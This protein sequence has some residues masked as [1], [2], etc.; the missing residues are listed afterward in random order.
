MTSILKIEWT[1][2]D[3]YRALQ[4]EGKE[5]SHENLEKLKD[6]SFLNYLEQKSIELGWE[7]LNGAAKQV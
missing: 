5:C 6:P 4:N 1:E 2:E 7:M 3:L